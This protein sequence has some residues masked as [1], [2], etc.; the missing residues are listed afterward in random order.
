MRCSDLY[1]M[2]T[3]YISGVGDRYDGTWHRL[4]LIW[5][6]ILTYDAIWLEV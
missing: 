4:Q 3:I 2:E 1:L 6:P 5:H